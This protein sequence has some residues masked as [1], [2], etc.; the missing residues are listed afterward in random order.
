MIEAI[1]KSFV[2]SLENI[3]MLYKNKTLL[4]LQS[5]FTFKNEAAGIYH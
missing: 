4:F 5:S 2:L 1:Y 3:L